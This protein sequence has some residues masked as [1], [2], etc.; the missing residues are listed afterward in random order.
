VLYDASGLPS[1]MYLVKMTAAD[2]TK[3]GKMLLLK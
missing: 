1:G 3:T 2:Y